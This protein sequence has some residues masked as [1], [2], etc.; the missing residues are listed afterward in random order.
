MAGYQT[1]T[2]YA[3]V[4]S[5]VRAAQRIALFSHAKPDGDAVGSQ[6]GLYRA[7]K[8]AGIASDLFVMGPVEPGL[9]TIA[10]D[11][12]LRPVE[13][14]PPGDDYD[15]VLIV[16]T[17]AWTQLEPIRM[18]ITPRRD[19]AIVL[20]HHAHGDDVAA[21]RMVNTKAP[22]SAS[23]VAELLDE[24][25]LELTGGPDGVAEPLFFAL[26]TDT[27]WFKF[28]NA[29][30]GAFLLAARLMKASIDKSKLYQ[31]SEE[32][33]SPSRI[34]VEARALSSL[35]YEL[36]GRAAFQFITMADLEETGATVVDLTG[37][38]NN[39][40]S[41][42]AVRVSILL[43]ETE[44]DLTKI[45]FR[46]K[47]PIDGER[48]IDVNELAQVFGGGGHVHAAGARIGAGID[49]AHRKVVEALESVA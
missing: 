29:D 20:D 13:D 48:L 35:K 41:V 42:G 11:T 34:A 36:G 44:P 45:S 28:A 19:R 46:S 47:P 27:G 21:L 14:D 40:M 25:G 43:T 10:G 32:S 4:A 12:P 23:L 26:A 38:V 33:F 31:I 24:M 39:P 6:L 22:A 17:G 18:W 15:L 2:T 3:E 49:Q 1:N 37:L 16:D 9:Y 8:A 7:F 5:R 30:A